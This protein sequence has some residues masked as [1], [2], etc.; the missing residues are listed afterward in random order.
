MA[1]TTRY[2]GIVPVQFLSLQFEITLTTGMRQ[3]T[4]NCY[5]I[6]KRLA[7]LTQAIKYYIAV[8]AGQYNLQWQSHCRMPHI[9]KHAF[10]L[11]QKLS[12]R[13]IEVLE[14]KFIVCLRSDII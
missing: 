11:A 13:Y 3:C 14:F 5:D 8:I 10:R 2:Q 1:K 4:F 12:C 9:G 7:C 6:N